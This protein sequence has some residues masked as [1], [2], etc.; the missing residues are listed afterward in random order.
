[1]EKGLSDEA[2]KVLKQGIDRIPPDKS[3]S[4]LYSSYAGVLAKERRIDEAAEILRQGLNRV[5]PNQGGTLVDSLI[6]LYAMR[7][8]EQ[9]MVDL[10][11]EFKDKRL[12]YFELAHTFLLQIQGHWNEAAEYAKQWR[13]SGHPSII[14][15]EAFSWL[16]VSQPIRALE[17]ISVSDDKRTYKFWLL[18]FIYLR[19]G[20]LEKAKQMLAMYNLKV[21][22]SVDI[23]DEKTLINEWFRPPTDLK[24]L[25]LIFCFPILPP[26]LTGLPQAITMLSYQPHNLPIKTTGSLVTTLNSND[27]DK[28][29]KTVYVS[30]TVATVVEQYIDFDL[31]IAADGHIVASSSEG[32]A[33]DHISTQLPSNIRLSLQLIERRQTDADLLKEVGNTLYAWL[34]P[35][36]IH[37]HFQQ[38]EAVARSAKKKLRLRLRIESA[39]IASLPLEFIYRE[40]GGYYMA[41]NP[42]TV[43]SRYLNLPVPPERVRRRESPLHML[44]IIADPADQVRLDPDE[45]E[46]IVKEAV[47]RPLTDGQMTFSTVKRATRK[48]IRD[49]LLAQ[50]PDII[51]FVGHGIYENGKGHLALVDEDTNKTWLVDDERFANIFLGSGDH[52]G[53]FVM[54]TCESAKSDDPQSFLG[55]APQLVQ[56][57][58]P[59]VVAMQYS[60]LIKTAKVFLDDFYTAVAARKPIDWAVQS[61]RNGISIQFGLENR[62]FAT[63]VL[64]MR[65][66]DGNVF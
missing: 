33:T 30:G 54:A 29:E 15:A 11:K 40:T 28:A 47:S 1:T 27:D 45:W 23:I 13:S 64:Y 19:L 18:A 56:R 57:G 35:S 46:S 26:A 58:T 39:P 38:T 22:P 50:K 42:E 12:P 4:T 62:E 44:T 14:A 65:A 5:H 59:A 20:N 52:L 31:H 43:L 7:N 2:I 3:L 55:I 32:Q 61:A 16:C 36:A 6:R 9:A 66:K 53:L 24:Q 8:D 10:I 60:V 37:T 41:V 51:Q 63:P 17:A 49:A 34:F 25:D 48:D 21:L